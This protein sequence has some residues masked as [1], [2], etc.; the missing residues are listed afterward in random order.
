MATVG[1]IVKRVLGKLNVIDAREDV[2]ASDS[3]LVIDSLN[4]MMYRWEA[5]GLANGWTEVA[6]PS[7]IMPCPK[8]V[9]LAIIY[10]LAIEVA[11]DFN[12]EPSAAVVNRADM[13]M[14]TMQADRY[15]ESP[16]YTITDNPFGSATRGIYF[17]IDT[18]SPRYGW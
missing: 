4:D 11:A 12:A 7:D 17:N 6:N 18:D 2:E 1:R 13:Y 16:L 15:N 3:E 14:R 9:E 5:N 10:N 8:E